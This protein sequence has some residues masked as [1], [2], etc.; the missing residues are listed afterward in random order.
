M[1][2]SIDPRALDE[3]LAMAGGDKDFLIAVVQEYL[4]DSAGAVEALRGASG[5]DLERTAHTLKSTSS[6]VGAVALAAI[7]S[8]IER[9]AKDGPVDAPLIAAAEAEHA[10]ARAAL[11]RHLEAM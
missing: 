2:E 11:E 7:C 9:A 6:S 10:S 3:V 1:P 5:A 4:S 8:D